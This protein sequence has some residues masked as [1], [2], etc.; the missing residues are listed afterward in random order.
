MA[1]NSSW[2]SDSEDVDS[3]F[4]AEICR[5]LQSQLPQS[6]EAARDQNPADTSRSC[7]TRILTCG[8]RPTRSCEIFRCSMSAGE[9]GFLRAEVRTVRT[10]VSTP[11]LGVEGEGRAWHRWNSN[12]VIAPGAGK[13]TYRYCAQEDKV[14][15]LVCPGCNLCRISHGISASSIPGIRHNASYAAH[16]HA[17]QQSRRGA[18]FG[19]PRCLNAM[20]KV[21]EIRYSHMF[22]R[23]ATC[24]EANVSSIHSAAWERPWPVEN[25]LSKRAQAQPAQ[26]VTRLPRGA[27]K[28]EKYSW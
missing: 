12:P 25:D 28:T 13:N 16:V 26:L 18:P 4:P 11:V 5:N 23:V 21:S 1:V 20:Q 14:C 6:L 22:T 7:S 10:D 27:R 15:H 9:A 3:I 2:K 17:H 19:F 24:A 8:D